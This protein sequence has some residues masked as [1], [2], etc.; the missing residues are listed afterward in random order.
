MMYIRIR[1]GAGQ[2]LDTVSTPPLDAAPAPWVS[3]SNPTALQTLRKKGMPVK[4]YIRLQTSA[5]G[6]KFWGHFGEK[7]YKKMFYYHLLS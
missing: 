7:I 4:L 6:R 5:R 2:Y 3:G 1:T